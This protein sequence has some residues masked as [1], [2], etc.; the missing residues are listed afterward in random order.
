MEDRLTR[1][2]FTSYVHNDSKVRP[3]VS[4]ISGLAN[5]VIEINGLFA[6]S[7][8]PLRSRVI[9][10]YS[11]GTENSNICHVRLSSV[12]VLETILF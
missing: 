3:S 9:S 2:F 12:G 11:E 7:K 1:F 8:V 4:S 5:A 10:L 6:E